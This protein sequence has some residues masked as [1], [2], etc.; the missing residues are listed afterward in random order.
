MEIHIV[1]CSVVRVCIKVYIYM[2]SIYCLRFVGEAI[3]REIYFIIYIYYIRV[4]VGR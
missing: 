4:P 3:S 1:Y 2:Y